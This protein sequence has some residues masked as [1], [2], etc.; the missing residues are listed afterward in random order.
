MELIR[1]KRSQGTNPLRRSKPY[2]VVSEGVKDQQ[3]RASKLDN[4]SRVVFLK[5][6]RSILIKCF[7]NESLARSM[8][9]FNAS[10]LDHFEG[11]D[12]A[13][14]H[15]CAQVSWT[16]SQWKHFHSDLYISGFRQQRLSIVGSSSNISFLRKF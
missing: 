9:I 5:R 4:Q 6:F 8:I 14:N 10:F 1:S 12:G 15:K 13:Q 7:F 3:G 16:R 2:N 11:S